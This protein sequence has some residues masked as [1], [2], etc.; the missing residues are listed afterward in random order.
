MVANE[1]EDQVVTLIG[2]RKIFFSVIDHVI[3]ADGANKI[4]IPRATDT[5]YFGAKRFRYLHRESANASGSA[6]DQYLLS[7]LNL[8]FVA[9]TLQS[10]DCRDRNGSRF[11]E[12]DVSGLGRDRAVRQ[13]ANV[14]GKRPRLSAEYFVAGFEVSYIFAR[15]FNGSRVVNA[16]SS[17][18]RLAQSR[19]RAQCQWSSDREV[20]RIHG[21]RAN[22]YQNLIIVWNWRCDILQ[23]KNIWRT[24]LAMNNRFHRIVRRTGITKALVSRRPVGDEEPGHEHEKNYARRPF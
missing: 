4:D 1:I 16:D 20:E 17:L 11:F 6:V 14:L 12:C 7:C 22:F 10:G 15:C 21:D 9:K 13:N 23:L 18:L 5:C 19:Y 8:S 2:L 3:G 24:V